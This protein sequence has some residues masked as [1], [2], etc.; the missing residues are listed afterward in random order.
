MK[1]TPPYWFS[2]SIYYQKNIVSC[3]FENDLFI[4]NH[5]MFRKRPFW[6]V[7]DIKPCDILLFFNACP[8]PWAVLYGIFIPGCSN[9]KHCIIYSTNVKPLRC[10]LFV[11]L[12]RRIIN[13]YTGNS[14]LTNWHQ[15]N[16]QIVHMPIVIAK[17]QGN[18]PATHVYPMGPWR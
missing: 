11:Q 13:C 10:F 8:S 5:D 16:I 12:V 18:I 1:C 9:N 14:P 4:G 3:T 15:W 17:Y 7:K 2:A 6:S